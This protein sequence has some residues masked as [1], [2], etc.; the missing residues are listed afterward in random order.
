MPVKV[1]KRGKKYRVV[2]SGSGKVAT[3]RTGTA[4]DGGGHRTRAG[5][6]DQVQAMNLVERR[7]AGKSAPPR[8][9]KR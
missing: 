3:N 1:Q 5:A 4:V 7:R 6:V 9:R 2:E 8:R